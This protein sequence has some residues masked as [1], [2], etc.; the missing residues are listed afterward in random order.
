VA[1]RRLLFADRTVTLTR[2]TADAFRAVGGTTHAVIPPALDPAPPASPA[3]IAAARAHAGVPGPFMIYPGDF[4]FSGG[5]SLLLDVWAAAADLPILLVTGRAKTP[6]AAG[7]RAA[8]EA[9]AARRGLEARV[10]FAETVP[11]MPALIA[12][13]EALLFPARSLHAKTDLPLVVL[14]AW[15]EG[16]PVLASDLAP[17]VETIGEGGRT[18][19]S[20]P[21]AWS[22]A[23]RALPSTGAAMGAAGRAQLESRYSART[24]ASAYEA[25]YDDAEPSLST[26]GRT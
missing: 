20:D 16:R 18:L 1:A 10:C 21:G 22:E 8:L 25:L 11:D 7:A 2:A 17:L 26:T 24:A 23:L 12:A 13:S 5:H 14:E 6:A 3:R 19:P 9:E 15:R 4:E